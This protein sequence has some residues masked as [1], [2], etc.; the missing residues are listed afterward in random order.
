MERESVREIIYIHRTVRERES[1]YIHTTVSY[2][3]MSAGGLVP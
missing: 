3:S 2:D 1:I